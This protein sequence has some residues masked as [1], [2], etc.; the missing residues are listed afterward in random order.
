MQKNYASMQGMELNTLV[1]PFK[2]RIEAAGDETDKQHAQSDLDAFTGVAQSA[3]S[4]V[5]RC[6]II[7]CMLPIFRRRL[8]LE[9]RK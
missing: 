5:W 3:L 1:A 6:R 7:R 4:T 8:T 2:K 9:E